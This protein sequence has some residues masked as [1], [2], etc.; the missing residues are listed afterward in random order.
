MCVV[1]SFFILPNA[2]KTLVVDLIQSRDAHWGP[3]G[4]KESAEV[5]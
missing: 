5:T 1:R 3:M 4:I 2:I